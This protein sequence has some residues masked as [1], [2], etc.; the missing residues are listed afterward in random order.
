MTSEKGT[1]KNNCARKKIFKSKKK[2][3]WIE[4][5]AIFCW[6]FWAHDEVPATKIDWIVIFFLNSKTPEL[7]V[8]PGHV[9]LSHD[10]WKCFEKE[11]SVT[12]WFYWDFCIQ[13]LIQGKN[14][15]ANWIYV[16]CWNK[17]SQINAPKGGC[18]D[19]IQVCTGWGKKHA[20]LAWIP[21]E[22]NIGLWLI[23]SDFK[24]RPEVCFT[25]WSTKQV[26]LGK[27]A[28]FFVCFLDTNS[29]HDDEIQHL[30][31]KK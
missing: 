17:S 23:W 24:T 10:Q 1:K 25:L 6:A 30:M 12:T 22:M 11:P 13:Y 19:K 7:C 4:Q 29:I 20:H 8:L 16:V 21:N 18:G 2:S 14:V 3:A 5:L 9:I 27:C 26:A 28:L 15:V 31:A